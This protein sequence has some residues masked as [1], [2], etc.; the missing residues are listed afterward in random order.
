ML[1]TIFVIDFAVIALFES[2]VLVLLLVT[3]T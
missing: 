2:R 1:V 3:I